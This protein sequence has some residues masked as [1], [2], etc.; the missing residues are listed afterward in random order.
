MPR[1]TLVVVLCVVFTAAV[2]TAQNLCPT[3]TASSKLV[4][5]IPQVYGINDFNVRNPDPTDGAGIFQ[6]D[7]LSS[8]L[9]SLQ[10]SI[11]RQS[12]LLPLASPSSGVIF[13]WDTAAK[14]FVATTDSYGPILGERADTIGRHRFFLG[15][16][17]QYFN[18]NKIDGQDLRNFPVVLPQADDSTTFPPQLQEYAPSMVT[19]DR[20]RADPGCDHDCQPY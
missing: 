20:L 1:A 12:A 10:S 16:S 14:V 15:F 19:A 2:A 4:C 5:L 6:S 11:A 18:F 9:S 3:G 8:S 13:S 7:F 17:Y